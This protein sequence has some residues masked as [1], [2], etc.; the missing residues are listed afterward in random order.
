MSR[1]LLLAILFRAP[2]HTHLH[3][4]PNPLARNFLEGTRPRVVYRPEADMQAEKRAMDGNVS[5]KLA[6]AQER[7]PPRAHS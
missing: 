2:L 5:N 4:V 3:Q 7:P 1:M 6:L